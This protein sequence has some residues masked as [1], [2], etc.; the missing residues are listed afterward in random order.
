MVVWELFPCYPQKFFAYICGYIAAVWRVEPDY[1]LP[2]VDFIR[3]VF[4]CLL[5]EFEFMAISTFL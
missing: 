3:M 1:G 2:A 5:V 4:P